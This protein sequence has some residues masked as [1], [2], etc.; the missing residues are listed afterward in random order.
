MKI[1]TCI[2]ATF[3]IFGLL[4]VPSSVF[5]Q[6]SSL[7]GSNTVLQHSSSIFLSNNFIPL[8]KGGSHV[9]HVSKKIH[10]GDDDDTSDTSDN[11]TD[12]DGSGWWIAIIIVIIVIA[13]IVLAVWFFF[14]RK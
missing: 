8:L 13:I 5:A 12:D 11:S 10:S 9:S 1:L 7:T 2:I 4:G 14:L 3:L 6:D